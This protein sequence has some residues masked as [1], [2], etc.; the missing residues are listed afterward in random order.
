MSH[1][2]GCKVSSACGAELAAVRFLRGLRKRCNVI[3][4]CVYV[5]DIIAL[6][7]WSIGVL[8]CALVYKV[9]TIN[10]DQSLNDTVVIMKVLLR[11]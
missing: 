3:T 11:A 6:H 1:N 5:S 7:A 8:L 4:L 10:F 9:C 2:N